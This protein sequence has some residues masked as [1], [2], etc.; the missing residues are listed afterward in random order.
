[1][2]GVF[3]KSVGWILTV[4]KRVSTIANLGKKQFCL[5]VELGLRAVETPAMVEKFS[6]SKTC[7]G[8]GV[9]GSQEEAAKKDSINLATGNATLDIDTKASN[10][11]LIKQMTD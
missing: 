1:M 4:S 5:F 10:S 3:S 6:A 7:S 2:P 11:E 9:K 8:F